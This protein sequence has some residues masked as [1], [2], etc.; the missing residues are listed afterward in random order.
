[1]SVANPGE[2]FDRAQALYQALINLRR[3]SGEPVGDY[4]TKLLRIRNEIAGIA[5]VA[6]KPHIVDTVPHQMSW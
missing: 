6:I 4:F 2:R 1:M 3:T 5:D